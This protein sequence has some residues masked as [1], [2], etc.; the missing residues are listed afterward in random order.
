MYEPSFPKEAGAPIICTE[1]FALLSVSL[2]G[3]Q[4][5]DP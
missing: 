4:G 2:S 1:G 5:A 3:I